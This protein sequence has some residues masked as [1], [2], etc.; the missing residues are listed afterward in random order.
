[1]EELT[2]GR[3]LGWVLLEA[4]MLF[5]LESGLAFLLVKV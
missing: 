1:M 5:E 3:R 2:L 4:E